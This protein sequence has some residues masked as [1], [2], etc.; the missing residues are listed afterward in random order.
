MRRRT[1]GRQWVHRSFSKPLPARPD[2]SLPEAADQL[3]DSRAPS[4]LVVDGTDRPIGRIHADDVLPSAG[5][6]ASGGF[7]GDPRPR[8][9]RTHVRAR[10]GRA[11]V[12]RRVRPQRRGRAGVRGVHGPSRR[13]PAALA[14]VPPSA[15]SS[16]CSPSRPSPSRRPTWSPGPWVLRVVQATALILS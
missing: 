2:T 9:E 3:V 5:G 14:D 4:L 1:H 16:P 10:Q 11:R 15:R 13:M 8:P 12:R 6:C 7:R